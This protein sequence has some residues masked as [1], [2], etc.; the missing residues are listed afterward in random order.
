MKY[1]FDSQTNISASYSYVSAEFTSG[2]LTPGN[3]GSSSCDF[4][5]TT[6]CSNSQTWQTLMGGGT[7]YSLAGKSV[8][9]IAP[10]TFNLSFDR[11]L[12]NATNLLIDFEYTD[13]KFVSNDQENVEKKIPAY[14]LINSKLISINGPFVIS[15]GVNNLLD[16]SYYNFAVSSTFHDDDHFGTQAV[17]PLA[18][19]NAFVNIGYSF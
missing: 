12:S 7:S 10:N 5:N 13:E 15:A 4:N 14:Y 9:L 16:K 18:G 17:Y 2:S 11:K 8:P 1:S 6:Y 19:R 3:G